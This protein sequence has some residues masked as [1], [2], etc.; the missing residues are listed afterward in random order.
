MH[1]PPDFI[2]GDIIATD[3][4]PTDIGNCSPC[5]GIV[6]QV[7]DPW[8]DLQTAGLSEDHLAAPFDLKTSIHDPSS[9]TPAELR[10]LTIYNNYV[11]LM[12]TNKGGGYGF[13]F[14][15][16]RNGT[17][18]GREYL[19]F[20]R[21]SPD[22][23]LVT[24]MV[25]VPARFD[26]NFPVV[27]TAPSSGSRGIYGAISMAEWA[28][29]KHCAVAYTDKGTAP[30]FHDLDCDTV[31]DLQG[32]RMNGASP[33]R[34]PVFRVPA[35]PELAD[36]KR[37]YPHR[38]GVKHAHSGKNIEQH[39]GRD[40]LL[41]IEFAF[42]CLNDYFGGCDGPFTCTNT[43]VIAAGISN[44]GGAA[45]RAAE[46]DD[47]DNP[48]IDAVVVSE[49]QVQPKLR[50]FAISYGCEEFKNHSRSL[51]DTVTLMDVYAPCAAFFLDPSDPSSAQ[52]RLRAQRCEILGARGLLK[53]HGPAAQARE[54][55]EIIH[56]HGILSETDFLLVSHL[57]LGVWRQL[58]TVYA[59]AYARA[60]LT[61]HL[62]GVSFAPV[63]QDG[64]PTQMSEERRSQLCGW[65]AGLS[66]F[67]SIADRS[68]VVDDRAAAIADLNAALCF[69]SLVTGV[70]YPEQ[71][72]VEAHSIDSSR[73][74]DG[75]A[76][77]RASGDLHGKPAIILHGRS[78]ALIPPNHSSRAYFGLNNL[79]ERGASRLS[80]IEVVSGNHFDH[81][82][83][84][85]GAD[86]LVPMHHYFTQALDAMYSHLRDPAAKPLPPSQV[87]P[88]T[89]CRK[90]WTD[91]S[92]REDLPD[93]AIKPR[94]ENRI[95]FR[96]RMVVIPEGKR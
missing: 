72:I 4:G 47:A 20:A 26:K 81:F 58:A 75:I 32:T 70:S 25:Q 28:F 5:T 84:F 16:A 2:V 21:R 3:Y 77:V 64:T 51:L 30:G 49:P 56:Q 22:D 57:N 93:I 94:E 37:R 68:D 65:C 88:A 90:P 82:I 59:N 23:V 60:G 31:Y 17:V 29:S 91:S 73:L 74:R 12:E 43:K 55:L 14:G 9:P 66:Y 39:W 76:K 86:K 63:G 8:D 27:V 61:D 19:A 92:Y 53:S 13:L 18:F 89:A 42:F 80:Y 7:A 41:S 15:P 71:S 83:P 48:L 95:R 67:L 54:A 50:D 69:R 1:P 85:F 96:D 44:G 34:E 46:Q 36:Y 62:C 10:R 87:V 52:Q 35:S 40:V 24:L 78:D 79:V 45:L 6:R 11:A 38:F 33:Q